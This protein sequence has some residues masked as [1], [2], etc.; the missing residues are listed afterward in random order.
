[1][2]CKSLVVVDMTGFADTELEELPPVLLRKATASFVR[3]PITITKIIYAEIHELHLVPFLPLSV[4][5]F[6]TI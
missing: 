4:C 2:R 3:F 6:F 1:M 5:L